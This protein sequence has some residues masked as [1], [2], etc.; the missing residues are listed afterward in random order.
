MDLEE[1]IQSIRVAKSTLSDEE[2][3]SLPHKKAFIYG[4]V[5][6]QGQI[7]DSHESIR[8][9]A[10]LVTIAKKDGYNHNLEQPEIEKWLDTIQEATEVNR[11]IED[12]DVVVDCRDLGLSGSLGQDRRPGL[13]ALWK[14]VESGDVGAVYLTE[15][16]SRLS[17]DR[18][19]I[20]GYKLLKLLKEQQCRIRTPEGIYNPAIR[21]DWENLAEDIED[22]ADEMRKSGIRLGRRRA[23]KAEEGRHVGSPVCPGYVVAIEGH[24]SDGSYILGKWLPYVPHQEVV[25]TALKEVVARGSLYQAVKALQARKIV[26]PFFPEE[27]KYMETRSSLRYYLRNSSGY[28]ITFN[29]LKG[30][31]KNIRLIGIWQWRDVLIKDNHPAVVPTDLFVQAYKI[32]TS[33]KPRGRAAYYEP[34]EWSGLLYCHNHEAPRKLTAMNHNQRWMCDRSY[35]MPSEPSCLH[36]KD[37]ILTSPLTKEFLNCLDLAPHAR[38][39]IERIKNEVEERDLEES[40]RRRRE[41]DLKAHLANLEGY[42]GSGDPEKEATYWRLIKETREQL[43]LTKKQPKSKKSTILD[44]ERV[45]QFLENLEDEWQKYP[46]RLRNKLLTLLIDRVELRHDLSRI[47]ATVVWKVGFKQMIVIKR[48]SM[49]AAKDNW[50]HEDE[51]DLLRMLWPSSSPETIL[52]AFPKRSWAALNQRASKLKI[53]RDQMRSKYE[54]GKVWTEAAKD[55]LRELYQSEPDVAEIAKKLKRSQGAVTTMAAMMGIPRPHEFRH[56]QVEPEWEIDN[57]K[58]LHELSS[59]PSS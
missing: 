44:L 29:A 33:T 31:V 5:S 50:W 49:N 2:M 36:I 53:N 22:S 14:K 32:A 45:T 24:K 47:E 34:M 18:D 1:I 43:E 23:S 26:F 58:V 16:M 19:R 46:Q 41:T 11:V 40:Q 37:Y 56:K 4:R 52:A 20:L 39:V 30:L 54:G 51:D 3:R 48:P 28:I 42:L 35:Q 57:M 13:G 12:G 55:Q 15:G 6:S 8:E 17:R 10:K 9:I 25:M 38:A 59:P 7:R 21:R 27:L